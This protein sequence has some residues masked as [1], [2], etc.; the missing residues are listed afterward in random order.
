VLFRGADFK[1]FFEEMLI[2]YSGELSGANLLFLLV[3]AGAGL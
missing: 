2:F 1:V 3:K